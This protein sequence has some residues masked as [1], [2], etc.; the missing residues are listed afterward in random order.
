[1][2]SGP[3]NER[4]IDVLRRTLDNPAL[5]FT[6]IGRHL[7]IYQSLKTPAVNPDRL[8]DSVYYIEIRGRVLDRTDRQPLPFTSIYIKDKSIGTVSNEEGRFLL[9]L[10]AGYISDTLIISCIGY[11]HITE[12]ISS[13]IS[14]NKDYLLKTDV[15]SIQEVII[16]KI[17]PVLLLQAATE[18]VKENYPQDPAVLTCFTAKQ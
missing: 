5:D 17:S 8:T 13:L 6:I 11:K 7:V 14:T 12:P 2:L 9:K 16:R 10:D 18:K 1:L 3:A 15:I 4:L